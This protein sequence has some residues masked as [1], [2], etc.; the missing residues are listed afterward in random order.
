MIESNNSDKFS[1]PDPPFHNKE[2][3]HADAAAAE[4]EG[5]GLSSAAQPRRFV[6]VHVDTADGVHQVTHV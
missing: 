1:L 3:T 5:S 2:R 6:N 4:R